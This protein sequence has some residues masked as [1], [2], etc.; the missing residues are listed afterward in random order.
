MGR[1]QRGRRI[2]RR[3]A[4]R[5]RLAPCCPDRVD[6]WQALRCQEVVGKCRLSWGRLAWGRMAGSFADVPAGV[7]A[8]VVAG[9]VAGA[10]RLALAHSSSW[11]VS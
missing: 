3:K 2:R 4:K 1:V 11:F 6:L 10:F 7:I 9:V 5:I 8:G